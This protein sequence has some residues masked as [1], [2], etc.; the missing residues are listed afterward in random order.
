MT[1]EW[2]SAREKRGR[3]ARARSDFLVYRPRN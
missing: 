3:V 2:I 1:S